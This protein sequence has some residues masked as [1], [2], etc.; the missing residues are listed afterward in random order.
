MPLKVLLN[1]EPRSFE[2]L[3]SPSPLSSVLQQLQLRPDRIAVE[4]NGEIAPRTSWD[5]LS[6]GENDRLEIVHFVGGGRR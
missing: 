1:G 2:E 5:A 6:V 4:L 3:S